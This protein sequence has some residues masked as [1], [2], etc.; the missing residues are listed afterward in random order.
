[1]GKPKLTPKDAEEI[2][3]LRLLQGCSFA[4]I[5]KEYKVS[6]QAVQ[7]V[8]KG[9]SFP[10]AGGPIEPP[11]AFKASRVQNPVHGTYYYWAR[12]CKCDLCR[13]WNAD[14]CAAWRRRTGNNGHQKVRR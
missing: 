14:R 11:H 8:V 12:G 4:A 10:D 2:R 9:R 6:A 7:G 1:M 5:G 3:F 13:D